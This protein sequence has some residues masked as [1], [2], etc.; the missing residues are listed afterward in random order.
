MKR[1]HILFMN[2][3]VG[4][5]SATRSWFHRVATFILIVV[6]AMAL[7]GVLYETISEARDQRS[8]P[9]PGKLVDVAGKKMHIDCMGEGTP[10]VILDSGLGDTYVSWVKVQTRIATSTRVCSF[11]R[12]GLG[13]SD[14]S[15]EPRTSM[16]V[17][18]ELH[19][20]LQAAGVASPYV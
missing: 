19:A 10:A 16:V 13:Y 2:H 12:A 8:N 7:A 18:Q 5:T 15:S 9:M 20:L 1:R 6:V 17:A 4:P 14:S 11:D 3:I